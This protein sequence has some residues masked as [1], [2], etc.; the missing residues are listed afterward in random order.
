MDHPHRPFRWR[1]VP[2]GSRAGTDSGQGPGPRPRRPPGLFLQIEVT[3]SR[4]RQMWWL[5]AGIAVGH[6]LLPDSLL[7]KASLLLKAL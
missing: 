2:A 3:F 5:L 6:V 4:P 1:H 7:E